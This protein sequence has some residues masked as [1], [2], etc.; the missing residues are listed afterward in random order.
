MEDAQDYFI[1]D[2]WHGGR[3]KMTC[4]ASNSVLDLSGGSRKPS[5]SD[6]LASDT[7]KETPQAG[8]GSKDGRTTAAARN[9]GTSTRS[10]KT[11]CGLP[12]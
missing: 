4:L 9:D 11:A 10:T 6:L 8:H 7:Q 5:H 3:V 1:G 2:S 12:G